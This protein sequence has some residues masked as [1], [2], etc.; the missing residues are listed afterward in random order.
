MGRSKDDTAELRAVDAVGALTQAESPPDHGFVGNTAVS[1]IENVLDVG[2]DGAGPLDSAQKC[3]DRALADTPDRAAAVDRVV[4]EHLRLGAAGGFITGVGGF[5]VLP[6]A[7]PANVLEFYLLATRMTA[8][9]AS[10]RGYDIRQQEIRTAVLLTLVGAEAEDLL[11]KAGLTVPSGRLANL[12]TQRLPG[13]AVMVVNKAIGF[14]LLAAAGGRTLSRLGRVVPVVGGVV[15]AG[16]D[17]YLLKRL[18]EQ[19]RHE[20]PPHQPR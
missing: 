16:F 12:A 5:I 3:A 4:R 9:I 15:G 7:L 18:S 11:V 8:A 6:V 2:I 10:I 1:L 19:A 14:R 17:A 20:F 13:P